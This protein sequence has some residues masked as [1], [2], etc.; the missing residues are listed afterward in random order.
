MRVWRVLILYF[1]LIM[2]GCAGSSAQLAI[3]PP[4]KPNPAGPFPVP[5]SSAER[6]EIIDR[7]YTHLRTNPTDAVAYAH[8]GYLLQQQGNSSA[9]QRA[10]ERALH[11]DPAEC[12][13][14]LH[15]ATLLA[16]KGESRA[17]LHQ[18]DLAIK[19]DANNSDGHALRGRLLRE[20][21]RNQEALDAFER[22]WASPRPSVPAG[23]ELARWSMDNNRLESA[24]DYLR[25]CLVRD[26]SHSVAR[27]MLAD[28]FTRQG[29]LDDAIDQWQALINQGAGGARAY[30]RL[31]ELYH[32][33]GRPQLAQTS[34]EQARRIAPSDGDARRIAAL[35]ASSPGPTPATPAYRSLLPP[36]P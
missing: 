25:L 22:A 28:V 6:T 26:P 27:T 36:Q 2:G 33:T 11:L 19:I 14:R 31:A 24:A 15:Y 35:L 21:G 32:R 9:A 5:A 1:G 16:E 7:A 4:Q 8:L 17:A 23:V 30:Y 3:V 20:L 13:T 18:V 34:F 29:R 12:D 10:Y